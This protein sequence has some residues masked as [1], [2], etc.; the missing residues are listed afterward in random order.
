[1]PVGHIHLEVE[2]AT[3]TRPGTWPHLS[4]AFNTVSGARNDLLPKF[5]LVA[6]ASQDVGAAAT[7]ARDKGWFQLLVGAQTEVPLQRRKARGKIQATTAKISQINEK[8]RL[9]EDKIA[10]ELQTAYNALTLAAE[11]VDQAELSMKAAF[12]SLERYRFAFE[13]GKIDLIYLNLLEAKANETE[14][15]LVESQRDWFSALAALQAALGLDPLDQAMVVAELPESERPGPGNLPRQQE[16]RS[17]ELN[18]DWERHTN[19]PGQP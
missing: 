8:L 2:G 9:Q 4:F 3:T 19:P 7:K 15:K 10:T 14:I 6:E 17:D 11:I 16:L 18:R 13:R 5:D 12:D 1:M